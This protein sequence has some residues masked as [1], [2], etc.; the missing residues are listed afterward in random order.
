[1]WRQMSRPVVRFWG[2]FGVPLACLI[3]IGSCG[4]GTRPGPGIGTDRPPVV[5]QDAGSG[6][7]LQDVLQ[8][9]DLDQIAHGDW[10]EDSPGADGSPPWPWSQDG[11]PAYRDVDY[12]AQHH[13][14]SANLRS[15]I[16]R[17]SGDSIQEIVERFDGGW[18]GR[19]MADI[20][21]VLSR[22]AS[23]NVPGGQ[24]SFKVTAADLAGDESMLVS[25]AIEHP[26]GTA[27]NN[28]FLVVRRGE[29]V[30][31]VQLPPALDVS[32]VT[33]LASRIAVLA[34]GGR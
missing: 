7:I 26:A 25:A 33:A 18:G 1:M 20:R 12:L 22:C 27:T 13:R 23:Y 31:T 8:V 21:A 10:I 2:L 16:R 34:R 5:S 32:V 3:T 29:I 24:V 4:G 30:T 9:N 28:L 15:F 17:P 6:T 14:V 19:S 11:C